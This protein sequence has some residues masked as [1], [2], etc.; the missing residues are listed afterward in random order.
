V[1][2]IYRLHQHIIDHFGDESFQSITE[3]LN[4]SIKR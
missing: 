3:S 1:S 4:T 2:R